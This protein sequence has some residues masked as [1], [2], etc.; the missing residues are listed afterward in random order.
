MSRDESGGGGNGGGGVSV[1][2]RKSNSDLV[3]LKIS[4]LCDSDSGKTSFLSRYIG[5]EKE[6]GDDHMRGLYL[7]DKT[8]IVKG[9]VISE[10]IQCNIFLLKCYI[11]NINV[12]SI[13]K[14]IAAELFNLPWTVER[15]LTIREPLIDF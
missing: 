4:L 11:Y 2:V 14:F 7:M 5:N 1:F 12:N 10:G 6:E 3:D 13:F 9:E 8:L 15:N